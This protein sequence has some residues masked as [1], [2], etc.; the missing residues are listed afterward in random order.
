[1]SMA[2]RS[3]DVNAMSGRLRDASSSSPRSLE[4]ELRASEQR[5]AGII[6]NA[7]QA[8]VTMTSDGIVTCWNR[9]AELTFG[10][11]EE[12]ALGRDLA[13]L[14]VPAEMRPMHDVALRRFVATGEG[15]LIGRTI[16]VEATHRTG[17]L[18][19]VELA[20]NATRL[21]NGWE[22][23]ALLHDISERRKKTAQI[24]N[25][26][27]HA[28]IGMALVRLDGTFLRVNAAFCRIVG[29]G[30]DELKDLHFKDLTHPEDVSLG[31]SEIAQ[32]TGKTIA[33][34]DL[35]KRYIHKCGRTVWVRLSVSRAE[36]EDGSTQHFIAQVQDMT[37]EREAE[38]R[39]RLMAKNTTDMIT[40]TDLAGRITFISPACQKILGRAPNDLIGARAFDLVHAEDLPRLR[41]EYSNL[42][43]TGAA[44]PVRWRGQRSDGEWIWLESSI[45]VLRDDLNERPTGF[46]DVVR[47]I[48]ERKKREDDL[49]Q[50]R[51]R[52]EQA[53]KSKSDFVANISHELR[54]PLNSII[55]FS[56]LLMEAPELEKETRR[57]VKLIQS[58]G[59]ALRSVINNVLDFSKLEAS[60]LELD[61]TPFDLRDF[62]K[63]TLALMEPQAAAKDVQ[64]RAL[65]GADVPMWVNGDSTRLR[66]I[67]LNLLSN[68]VKFTHEGSVILSIT[69]LDVTEVE[70]RLRFEVCDTGTGIS[71][72]R[73][74][75]LF[76]R[77]VQAG[78]EIASHYGGTGLG[79]A[80]SRQLVQLMQGEIGATSTVGEG[81]TFWF[82][83]PL[84][85]A[86]QSATVKY[87][88]ETQGLFA[89]A[90]RNI[91]V[92]DDV[93]L[94]RDLML[95]TLSRC[96]VQVALANDGD[97]AVHA[98]LNGSYDLVLMDCQM[99]V[100]DGFTATRTIRAANVPQSRVPIVALTASAQPV[101]LQRCKDAGMDDHLSK[102]LD[103]A[104]LERALRNLLP[105]GPTTSRPDSSQAVLPPAPAGKPSVAE[106][107]RQRKETTIRQICEA[108]QSGNIDNQSASHLK[109][110][111][112]QLAGTAGMFGEQSLG[113]LALQLEIGLEKWSFEERLSRTAALYQKLVVSA[114][115]QSLKGML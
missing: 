36:A 101:H 18:I 67:V 111:A 53:V 24:Q 109:V 16:E 65:L 114:G 27:N 66:Q 25:A 34:F 5:L 1:M 32:L 30:I 94:N 106:R 71:A 17:A 112:H 40:S 42:R 82:E 43:R 105:S 21:D 115:L 87:T 75:T 113:E 103:E 59:Q 110:L 89:F 70:Q 13:E 98:V 20:I 88:G 104:Q 92:V 51:A 95:A 54:T 10:W 56:H 108:I 107:Y 15:T 23:T 47:D 37:N 86:C 31:L 48:T 46:I 97:Q 8:I 11:S 45:G 77:F 12:E 74:E 102:P 93:D 26:F 60:S 4:A 63:Q 83:L 7:Q 29:Y 78:P 52:A 35:D 80:I 6:A 38:N 19:P 62:A 14:I 69:Q 85:H 41:S 61:C 44:E 50:A 39:Y 99:P 96:G 84:P 33:S 76:S 100:M 72:E 55:G 58:A 28:P 73:I 90:G 57:R 81:T 2:H 49:D 3:S 79:L 9:Q 68:A 91:L 22:F 64:L